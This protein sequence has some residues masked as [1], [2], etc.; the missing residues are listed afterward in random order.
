MRTRIFCVLAVVALAAIVISQ[1][2]SQAQLS[3][4]ASDEVVATLTRRATDFLREVAK[5]DVEEGL[6]TL[7]TD[8]PLARDSSRITLIHDSVR[9]EIPRYG[10]FLGAES[11]AAERI[12]KALVRIT[13]LYHCE[14]YPVIWNFVFYRAVE[15]GDWVVISL[16]YNVEYEKLPAGPAPRGPGEP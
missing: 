14:D 16:Q 3:D 15:D 4:R 13:C 2:G 1:R 5:D 6:R 12:G 10:I 9:R 11:L 7:L 8:S